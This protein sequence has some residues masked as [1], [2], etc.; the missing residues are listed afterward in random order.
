M[1]DGEQGLFVSIQRFCFVEPLE[2]TV[3]PTVGQSQTLLGI[4]IITGSRWTLVERHHDVCTDTALNVHHALWC[5]DV[6]AAV[7][8]A[9]EGAT[10]LCELADA[11][12]REHLEAAAICED[13]AIPA[14]ESVE[15]SRGFEHSC[16]RPQV[17]VVGIAQNDLGFHLFVQVTYCN[18]LDAAHCAHGHE[19]GC[20][21]GAVWCMEETC[22]GLG[23]C[24][25]V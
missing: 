22:S 24:I 25:G 16:P 2:A 15:T 20:L 17:Q 7:D 9:P 23:L 1:N 4:L 10:L 14:V 18:S 5:K 21:Y 6:F 13:R 11:C 19:D 8:M 3:Q 12:E